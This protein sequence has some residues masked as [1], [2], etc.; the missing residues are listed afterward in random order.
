MKFNFYNKIFFLL[1]FLFFNSFLFAY[2]FYYYEGIKELEKNNINS[3]IEL[4]KKFIQNTNEPEELK[5][6][7]YNLLKCYYLLNDRKNFNIEKKKIEKIFINDKNFLIKINSFYNENEQ[8]VLTD[9]EYIFIPKIFIK[10]KQNIYSDSIFFIEPKKEI[11][12]KPDYKSAG[13]EAL[14]N[15]KYYLALNYFLEYKKNFLDDTEINY[16]ISLT[17]F[18]LNNFKEAEKYLNEYLEYFKNNTNANLLLAKIY[19]NTERI[20]EAEEI[21][22]KENNNSEAETL[23]KKIKNFEIKKEEK[24]EDDDWLKELEK[25]IKYYDVEITDINQYKRFDIAPPAEKSPFDYSF[26]PSLSVK[27]N[28]EKNKNINKYSIN[29][30]GLIQRTLEIEEEEKEKLLARINNYLK[31]QLS[32]KYIYRYTIYNPEN[33]NEKK[34]L[35]LLTENILNNNNL[36]I[37]V[38]YCYVLISI[39]YEEPKKYLIKLIKN[40]NISDIIN[41]IEIG[42]YL[43]D[44]VTNKNIVVNEEYVVKPNDEI[45]IYLQKFEISGRVQ[46]SG[47][48]LLKKGMKIKDA[49]KIAKPK[50]SKYKII[51]YRNNKK[52][53]NINE[54]EYIKNS[55]KIKIKRKLFF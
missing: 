1:F 7:Y 54:E 39:Y 31:N 13:L 40:L 37:N 2:K 48:Y 16:F 14:K 33:I 12:I 53:K 50:K 9:S 38:D 52:Y 27:N 11:I 44:K 22:K 34:E 47:K 36:Y 3:A 5:K 15:K 24:K 28:Q 8:S 19:I 45:N 17:Y 51:V 30:S 25:P 10:Q 18:Y 35:D 6:G 46:N 55:D 43:I 32:E 42:D 20:I 29:F 21:L 41:S 26:L 23:L 49:L 4:L